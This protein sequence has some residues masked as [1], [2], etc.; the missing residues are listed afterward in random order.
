MSPLCYFSVMHHSQGNIFG[1]VMLL[2][3]W[4]W[5]GGLS[6]AQLPKWL[7]N[8]CCFSLKSKQSF[9]NRSRCSMQVYLLSILK[10]QT[11]C[12]IE[13]KNSLS[14]ALQ[15]QRCACTFFMQTINL[16]L[17]QLC[18]VLCCLYC[19]TKN[20]NKCGT[21]GAGEW[22]SEWGAYLVTATP[23]VWFWQGNLYLSQLST[24]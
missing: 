22:P 3:F 14:A 8:N 23:T 9:S 11:C 13:C 24:V 12:I 15:L 10:M 5:R 20:L 17:L 6:S 1:Q 7:W 16:F 2:V 18:S 19:L 21:D 4:S